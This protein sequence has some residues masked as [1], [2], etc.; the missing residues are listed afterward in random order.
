VTP[1]LR[2]RAE[3]VLARARTRG[4]VKRLATELDADAALRAAVVAV[5]RERGVELPDEAVEA[6]PAKRLL[7][8]ARGREGESRIRTNPVR[9]DEGFTCVHCGEEVP[10]LGVTDRDHCPFCLRSLHVDVVPGDRAATCGGVFDPVGLELVSGLPVLHYRCRRCGAAHRV[11][12]ATSGAVPDRY[13]LL[14]KVSA[15]TGG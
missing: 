9:R 8:L 5:G 10:P 15:G 12:A 7:R 4:D 13:E 11:K 6:W 2:R 14:M 3:D 1:E